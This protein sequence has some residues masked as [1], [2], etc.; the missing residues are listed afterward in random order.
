MPKSASELGCVPARCDA[1]KAALWSGRAGS[2]LLMDLAWPKIGTKAPAHL[3]E[4]SQFDIASRAQS[5][6]HDESQAHWRPFI[7]GRISPS[8][9]AR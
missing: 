6:G 8:A 7:F 1:E 3:Y 2:G 4:T 9:C 5:N